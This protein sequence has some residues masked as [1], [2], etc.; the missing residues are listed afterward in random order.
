MA[1]AESEREWSE[2][3]ARHREAELKR[4]GVTDEELAPRLR[5]HG[6]DETKGS[7]ANKLAG[8]IER[9][10][11]PREPRG[12]RL[13]ELAGRR[14]LTSPLLWRA[15]AASCCPVFD[16]RCPLAGTRNAKQPEHA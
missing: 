9:S 3:I 14:Y 11:F 10:F 13:S 12:Y 15:G 16:R 5:E 6:F 4:A 2:R 8:D 1:F 7:S